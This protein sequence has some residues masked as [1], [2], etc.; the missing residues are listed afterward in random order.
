MKFIKYN[1]MLI[2]ASKAAQSVKEYYFSR[3]LR[4]IH[5]L[6]ASGKEILN[7]AIGNPDLPPPKKVIEVLNRHAS[8]LNEHGYQSYKGSPELRQAFSDWYAKYF[9]VKSYPETEIL[10]VAG[11][12]A[13]IVHISNAFLNEGDEV[14]IPNP[15]Y[16]AYASAAKLAGAR[17]VT[18][19]LNED[20]NY[21][22]DLDELNNR[23]LS[24]VKLMWINYP[25]MPTGKRATK[26]L[27]NKLVD[28]AI[29]HKILI[30][31]DNPYSFILN[32]E[33][34]SI[35]SSERA[36]ECAIELNSLSK[37][38]NMAGWRIGAIFGAERYINEILKVQSN[39]SSGMFL[40]VQKAAAEALKISSDWYK[41]L[42][43]IYTKRKEKAGRLMD[44]LNCSYDKDTSGMFIW[45][46]IPEDS[47]NDLEFSEHVLNT[48]EIFICPGS[49]FGKNGNRHV[50]MSLCSPS[51]TTEICIR[52]ILSNNKSSQNQ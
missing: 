39:M 50:R 29:E 46:R 35:L 1:A 49:V 42:N 12:K 41:Q 21:L 31:H 3:K 37:S 23:D 16:P 45:A 44:L 38:H 25:H 13:G 32:E 19:E 9:S 48:Y 18:Y 8:K 15:G 36:F 47:P 51:E 52:R 4:E 11:S 5:A 26:D 2:N 22:P 40:P 34:L 30:C 43:D 14:L 10:P 17:A 7:L 28:F 24:N 6:N 20:N 27:F 33:Q